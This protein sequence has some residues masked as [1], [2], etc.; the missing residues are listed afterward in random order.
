M[1]MGHGKHTIES[2]VSVSQLF[3]VTTRDEGI[4]N[5]VAFT[6]INRH[7]ASTT[8]TTPRKVHAK[9]DTAII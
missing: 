4:R 8:C 7:P 6:R 2:S 1:Y 9:S 5:V 3:S